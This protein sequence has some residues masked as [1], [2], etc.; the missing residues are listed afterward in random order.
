MNQSKTKFWILIALVT[1]YNFFFWGEKLGLNVFLFTALLLGLML[2]FNPVSWEV[3]RV[4]A[5]VLLTFIAMFTV[6]IF[7]SLI[8]KIALFSSFTISTALI[9]ESRLK[10][11]VYIL[12]YFWA[13]FFQAFWEMLKSPVELVEKLAQRSFLPKNI[14]RKFKLTVIP[15]FTFGIFFLIFEEANP[16]LDKISFKVKMFFVE[17]LIDLM[18]GLYFNFSAAK[19][20]FIIL[21]VWIVAACIY[22]RSVGVVV[23]HELAKSDQIYRRRLNYK[24]LGLSIKMIAL[25]N[26]YIMGLVMLM[27]VNGLLLVVNTIDITWL[28][29]GFDY[30]KVDNFK[31][32]VHKGTHMLILSI[33]LSM[34]ILLFFFRR[35]LNFYKKNTLLKKLSYL[36]IIQNSILAFNVALRTY[37][38]INQYGLA[39]KRIGLLIFLGL[40]LF[41]LY[42][43]YR[44]IQFKKSLYYLL[45]VNTWA[46]YI[47]LVAMSLVDWDMMIARYNINHFLSKKIES[48]NTNWIDISF[49]MSHADKTLPTIHLEKDNLRCDDAENFKCFG[50]YHEAMLN[51]RIENF[52]NK[53]KTYSWLSWN[54]ADYQTFQYLKTVN[55]KIQE[56]N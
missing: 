48:K 27:L 30:G 54:Y 8:A 14:W 6:L 53:Q 2:Y 21:G 33:L 51:A 44:K 19:F 4:K 41:G 1:L 35:N 16:V 26:E 31:D 47:V 38:Y 15:V 13:S 3:K 5:S 49:L 42:S 34:G 50:E 40:T 11:V 12:G 22:R 36:W 56:K 10:S 17:G 20:F 46:L 55:L 24:Q 32:M 9:H 29:I 23:S 18:N 39:Y 28:W 7:N 45:R 25:K 52:L 43:L 37:Y